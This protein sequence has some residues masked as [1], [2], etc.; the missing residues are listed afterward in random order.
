MHDNSVQASIIRIFMVGDVVGAAG[1]A[2]FQKHIKHLKAQH[3]IDAIIVN[4]ENSNCR[5]RGISPR[6]VHFFKHNGADVVTSGNHIWQD[7]EIYRY[8]N[9]HQD[10]LRPDNYPAQCPGRGIT[11]F[12]CKGAVIGVLNLQGNV[13][14]R[15]QLACPFRA[16]DSALTFLRNKTPIIVVDFHAETTA[17]KRAMGFYLDGR[18]SGVVGT[19]THVQTADNHILERGTA[20]LTDLGMCGSYNSM[21]GMKKEPIIQSFLTQMPHKFEVETK[22]PHILCGALID[23]DTKTGKALAISRIFHDDH[24]LNIGASFPD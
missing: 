16:A 7:K 5:G 10:L 24:D 1:R 8:L 21:I 18:V 17:E 4:G 19:H 12:A 11:T 23:V 2:M 15:E 6:D 13:F 20:Y 9:E 14:M 3:N 22:G